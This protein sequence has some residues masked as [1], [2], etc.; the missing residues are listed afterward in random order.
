MKELQQKQRFKKFVYSTPFLVV[1]LIV[2][3]LLGRGAWAIVSKA[4]ESGAR[5]TELEEQNTLLRERQADLAEEIGKLHTDE[6]VMAE[7]RTKFN[8]AREGEHLVVIV[9]E[10]AKATTT[11][12]SALSQ[13]WKWFKSLWP[14]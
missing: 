3:F 13:G 1:L 10:Q 12:P 11:P 2:A 14:F 6:G 9:D 4:R 5:L 7:I 8:A